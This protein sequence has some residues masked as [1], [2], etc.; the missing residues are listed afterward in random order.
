MNYRLLSIIIISSSLYCQEQLTSLVPP[1][2]TVFAASR[3][4][5]EQKAQGAVPVSGQSC[6]FC[7]KLALDQEQLATLED[8]HP[9][10]WFVIQRFDNGTIVT[11]NQMPYSRGHLL[12]MPEK[13]LEQFTD[14]KSEALYEWAMVRNWAGPLLK[15]IYDARGFNNGVNFGEL[16]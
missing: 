10:K 11:L 2:M 15:K 1:R 6:I 5:Y 3:T 14:L 13:H 9:D 8:A 12:L 7:P 4:A 16:G